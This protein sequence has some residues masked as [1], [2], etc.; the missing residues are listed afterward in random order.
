VDWSVSEGSERRLNL[1][2]REIGG[3]TVIQ[4]ERRGFGS[5]LIERNVR[6]DL[7]GEVKLSYATEGFRA[8]ISIPLARGHSS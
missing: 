3:P 4:P 7:A 6:H 8:E 2:W 1:V 5:R